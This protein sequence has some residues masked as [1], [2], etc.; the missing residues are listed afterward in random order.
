VGPDGEPI[1]LPVKDSGWI[2][3]GNPNMELSGEGLVARAG[4][5]WDGAIVLDLRLVLPKASDDVA[6]ADVVQ[7]E[8]NFDGWKQNFEST[9]IPKVDTESR[10]GNARAAFRTLSGKDKDG[11]PL[12]IRI[13][14]ASIKSRL[15]MVQVIAH[16]GAEQKELEWMKAALEG[17]AWED[18]KAGVRGPWAVPFRTRTEV[19]GKDEVYDQ[20]T[21]APF[22][23]SAMS[24]TKPPAWGRIKFSASEQ[25]RESWLFAGEAREGDA[26]VFAGIQRFTAAELKKVTPPK[27]PET[28]VDDL[29]QDWKNAVDDPVTRPKSPKT[30]RKAGSFASG[31]GWEFLFTG[32]K[33]GQP[34]VQRGWVVEAKG[35]VFIVR[36]QFGG[37]DAEKLLNDDWNDLRKTIRFE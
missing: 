8:G 32:T 7:N 18:T 25:G 13:Y 5:S 37:K 31:Q 36:V 26:L 28:F 17:L 9:P 21:K 4:M 34:W 1:P 24:L 10:V 35:N 3:E 11:N 23:R 27:D 29:E 22:K 19:R 20:G 16:R 15:F 12:W 14:F 6:P 33:E 30:N 2:R